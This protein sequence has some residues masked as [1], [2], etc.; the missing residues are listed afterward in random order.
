MGKLT[1][2]D[3]GQMDTYV[4]VYDQHRKGEDDNPTIGLVL[5]SE[6]SK[7]VAKYSVL[8]DSKQ[9]FAS[10]YRTYLPTEEELKK[11]LERERQLIQQQLVN[12]TDDNDC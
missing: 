10:E 9:L 12:N 2:Q 5:C 8:A 6:N 3:V 1:H 4:R 11:E 7:A